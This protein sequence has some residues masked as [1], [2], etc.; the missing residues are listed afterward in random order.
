MRIDHLVK[1]LELSDC[2]RVAAVVPTCRD[3]QVH[4]GVGPGAEQLGMLL[5]DGSGLAPRVLGLLGHELHDQ[6]HE[7]DGGRVHRLPFPSAPTARAI[8]L[9]A[10]TPRAQRNPSG[11]DL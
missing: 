5:E 10:E 3:E 9:P 1:I 6:R 7:L 8:G 11:A 4:G 2:V